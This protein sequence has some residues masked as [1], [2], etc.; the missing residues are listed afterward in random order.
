[1]LWIAQEPQTMNN[2]PAP[3]RDNAGQ[4]P[5]PTLDELLAM[6]DRS[7]RAIVNGDVVPVSEV[8]ADLDA[9]IVRLTAKRGQTAA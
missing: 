3:V 1:M 8:L 4:P 5:T 2:R 7:D 9:A 6:M